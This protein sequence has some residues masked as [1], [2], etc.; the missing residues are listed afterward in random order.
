MVNEDVVLKSELDRAV[1]NV[2]AQYASNPG[3]L[4]PPDVLRRQ[5]LERLVLVKLQV[6][7][8]QGSG[9][10][11]AVGAAGVVA[12]LALTSVEQFLRD[13]G[14]D[15]ASPGPACAH[16]TK[17]TERTRGCP[18]TDGLKKTAKNS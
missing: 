18:G 8:A 5:V 9:L 12:A 14:V 15:P 6:A 4:P 1:A 10:G 3:Q 16:I 11:L 17:R 7:R 2:Q 13:A